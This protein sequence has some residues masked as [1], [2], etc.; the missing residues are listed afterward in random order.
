MSLLSHSDI[1]DERRTDRLLLRK[2]DAALVSSR[3][4]IPLRFATRPLEE[5]EESPFTKETGAFLQA[6]LREGHKG[7]GF[8]LIGP[9]GIG[10][11]ATACAVLVDII[12]AERMVR[13]VTMADLIRRYQDLISLN[14]AMES[15]DGDASVAWFEQRRLLD[16]LTDAAEV[17]VLDDVGKEHRTASGWVEHVFDAVFRHRYDLGLPTLL[18]SNTPLRN[19][20]KDYSASMASFVLEAAPPIEINARDRRHGHR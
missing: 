6:C 13:Y 16:L 10:K 8:S 11:T 5:L 20:G 18:T 15:G 2:A 7:V 17:L 3:T 4:G 1:I 14:R 12:E 19:W 9:P